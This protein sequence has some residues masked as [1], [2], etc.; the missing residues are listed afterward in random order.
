MD[1]TLFVY[2]EYHG[3]PQLVGSL[4]YDVEASF[5][6]DEEYLGFAGAAPIS[7]RLPLREKPFGTGETAAFFEGLV[8]EGSMRAMFRKMLHRDGDAYPRLLSRLGDESIGAIMFSKSDELDPDSRGYVE[9]DPGW[10]GSFLEAPRRFAAGM[11]VKTR[12][13]LAGAQGKVGLYRDGDAWFMPMGFAPSTH[14]VKIWDADIPDETLN[15]AV[16]LETARILEL[17]PEKFSLIGAGDGRALIALERYDRVVVPGCDVVDGRPVPWRLHQEDMCQASGL[18]PAFKYEPTDGRYANR[19]ATV[20]QERS[21][22]PSEDRAMAFDRLCF[23]YL[24]GNCDNHLKNRALLY[25]TDWGEARLAPLYDVVS[26]AVYDGFDREMG[27]SMCRS[28]SIDDV[29][30]TD[31][32]ETA[33]AMG[34]PGVIA[35]GVAQSYRESFLPALRQAAETVGDMGYPAA[36]RVAERIACEAARRLDVMARAVESIG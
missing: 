31:V 1:E 30:P 21:S 11:G 17:K 8:P 29:T 25:D 6:Y 24:V 27:V 18:S 33:K 35:R 4:A 10:V 2:R 26:T 15:E 14:I 9:L 12:L 36:V 28:R 16:C 23:D 20:L 13:S 19:I 5:V 7:L 22:H 34:V 3:R 32:A